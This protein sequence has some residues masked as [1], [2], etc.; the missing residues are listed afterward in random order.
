MF[1]S[2]ARTGAEIMQFATGSLRESKAG[3]GR[4]DLIPPEP[5]QRLAVHYELGAK[6]HAD[7]N[8]ELGQPLHQ[9]LDSAERHLNGFKSG[10]RSEDHLAAVL[11]NICGYMWTEQKIAE[12]KLPK[13][14]YDVPWSPSTGEELPK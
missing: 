13:D 3:K 8:W 9:Y 11:W 4:F 10:E 7:R 12:G 14:L 2:V 5:M 1:E 6:A